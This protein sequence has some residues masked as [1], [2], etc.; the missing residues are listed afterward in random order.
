MS[1]PMSPLRR[2]SWAERSAVERAYHDEE[3]GILAEN[4]QTFFMWLVL[5][6]AQAG[7]SWRTVLEKRQGYQQAFAD[8]DPVS[9]ATFGPEEEA[10]LLENPGIIRNRKKIHSAVVNARALLALQAAEGSFRDFLLNLLGPPRHRVWPSAAALPAQ[11]PDSVRLSRTLS[12]RGFCWIG[13]VIAYSF[14]Q[15]TGLVDD[16]IVGCFRARASLQNEFEADH[17]QQGGENGP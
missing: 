9:I 6:G 17:Q 1:L 12:A 2:C 15:A 4:D 5:E 13:P 7:L 16:H 11:T 8:F 10:R 14:M 3:W